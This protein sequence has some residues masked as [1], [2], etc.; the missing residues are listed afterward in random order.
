MK[1][2]P[3]LMKLNRIPFR[4]FEKQAS[5]PSKIRTMNLPDPPNKRIMLNINHEL[6]SK[7]KHLNVFRCRVYTVDIGLVDLI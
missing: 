1:A 3:K 6:C 7:D 4:L 5:D 2:E